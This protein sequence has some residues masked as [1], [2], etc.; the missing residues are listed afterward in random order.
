MQWAGMLGDFAE[1]GVIDGRRF[2]QKVWHEYL[3]EK[4]LPDF[5]QDGITLKGYEKWL[6]MPSGEIRL[7]GST[8]K[9]TTKGFSEYITQCH[10]FGAGELGIRFTV[11]GYV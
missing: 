1:Q 5:P 11:V 6:E 4:F 3:K 2:S 9:L 10:A 8:T 7:V